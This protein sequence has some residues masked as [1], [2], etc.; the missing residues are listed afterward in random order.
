M[1]M[2][3]GRI[4]RL[5]GGGAALGLAL[6]TGTALAVPSLVNTVGGTNSFIGGG[7]LNATSGN[8]NVIGGG[9]N[10]TTAGIFSTIA[11]G[12]RSSTGN[13]ATAHRVTDDYGF[14]GGGGRHPR[15]GGPRGLQNAPLARGAPGQAHHPT[16]PRPP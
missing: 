4:G 7:D 15:R 9:Q 6:L 10:N 14:S 2:R 3:F 13:A 11:G 12:G 5:A 8:F 16:H 1:G